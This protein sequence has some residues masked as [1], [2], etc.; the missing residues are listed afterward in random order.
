MGYCP[1]PEV[2]LYDASAIAMAHL[3]YFSYKGTLYYDKLLKSDLS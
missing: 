3:Q 1:P 2:K